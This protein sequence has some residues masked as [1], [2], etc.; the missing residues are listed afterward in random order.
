VA[1][2]EPAALGGLPRSD[3]YSSRYGLM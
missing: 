3:R 2:R 1:M